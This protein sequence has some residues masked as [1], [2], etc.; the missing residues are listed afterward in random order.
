MNG[1][2]LYLSSC[3]DCPIMLISPWTLQDNQSPSF[4][5]DYKVSYKHRNHSLVNLVQSTQLFDSRHPPSYGHPQQKVVNSAQGSGS[6]TSS[7]LS[8]LSSPV[9]SA[10]RSFEKTSSLTPSVDSVLSCSPPSPS[11]TGA[12]CLSSTKTDKPT[13]DVSLPSSLGLGSCISL[14]GIHLSGEGPRVP[15]RQSGDA[16]EWCESSQ[17]LQLCRLQQTPLTQR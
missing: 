16:V 13:S 1:I 17:S 9:R 3:L 11:L 10:F 6:L 15:V 5:V 14:F 4:Y 8:L 7:G 2:N 12:D